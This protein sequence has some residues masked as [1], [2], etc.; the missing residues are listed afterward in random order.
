MPT[1]QKKTIAIVGATGKQ[2]GSVARTFLSAPLSSRWHVRCLTRNPSS[3]AAKG[4]AALGAEILQADLSSTPSLIVA[5]S[6][7][8]AIF[9]NTDFW[10]VYR[11]AVASGKSD[12]DASQLAYNTEI[13]WGKNAATAAA[14]TPELERFV[15]SAFGSMKLAS[16]GKYARCYHFEA[17]AVVADHITTEMPQLADK[18]SFFYAS[19]YSDN[20]LIYPRKVPFGT[21]WVLWLLSKL[22]FLVRFIPRPSPPVS[23][24]K[25]KEKKVTSGGEYLMILPGNLSMKLPVFIPDVSTGKYVRC[26]VED[27]PAGTRLLAVDWWIGMEEGMQTWGKVTGRKASFVQVTVQLL[28]QLTGLREEVVEGAAFLAEFPYMCEVKNWIEPSGLKNPPA[29]AMSYEEYLRTRKL[30]DLLA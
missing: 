30:E 8:S 11:P 16:G 23:G 6:S 5:F 14:Q 9:V 29:K 3:E 18:T 17:K 28:C 7:A 10:G 24:A 22:P 12:D 21:S 2:G 19:A 20:P 13:S 15:Y 27:D 4:L 26:L 25:G 1:G